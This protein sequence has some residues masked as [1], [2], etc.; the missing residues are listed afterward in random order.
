MP[1]KPGT[2]KYKRYLLPLNRSFYNGMFKG[3]CSLYFYNTIQGIAWYV[4]APNSAWYIPDSKEMVG[5][6]QIVPP[7]YKFTDL[8]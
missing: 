8:V 4:K 1:I 7:K 5:D 3:N 2:N 6:S